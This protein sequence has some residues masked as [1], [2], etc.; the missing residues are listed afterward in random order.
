MTKYKFEFLVG[1]FI[2]LGIIAMLIILFK[3]T[4]IQDIKY[5]KKKYK[6]KAMF[7]NIGNL[8]K[9]AKVTIGG[10]KIGYVNKI[11]LKQ[12]EFN[13]YVPEIEMFI[14]LNIDYIPKDSSANIFMTNLLGENYVQ[15]E[16]GYDD[17][18]LIDGDT[19]IFTSQ[20]IIIEELISKLVFNK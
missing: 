15:I 9:M 16:L 19:I 7:K 10:V 11:E 4:D 13:E 17:A 1:I 2:I 8:K 5:S 12:N 6:I 20:A 18:C 3:I 14:H